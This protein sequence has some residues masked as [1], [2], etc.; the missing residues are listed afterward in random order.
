MV[1]R[2]PGRL[3]RRMQRLYD[4]PVP[5]RGRNWEH[6]HLTLKFIYL[7]L[8]KS[9]GKLLA[10]L[11][12]A[13][14]ESKGKKYDKLHQFLNEIGLT[15]LR[16]HIWQVVGI[17]KTSQSVEEYERRFSLAFGGQLPFEFDE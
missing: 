7:P 9:N 16:A 6:Y 12:E 4:I 10:L 11:K 8:A 2:V 3:I 5:V 13:K 15:A 17:A 1:E 14:K